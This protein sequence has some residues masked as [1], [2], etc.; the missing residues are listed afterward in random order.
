[1]N[2][3]KFN[4][5]Q[6]G[7]HLM[8]AASGANATVAC[9][10]C[11]QAIIV[12][13]PAPAMV[14]PERTMPGAKAGDGPAPTVRNQRAVAAK[15]KSPVA[16]VAALALGVCLVG[17]VLFAFRENIF[18]STP[19]PRHVVRAPKPAAQLCG[20]AQAAVVQCIAKSAPAP[21]AILSA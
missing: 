4:C 5:P 15:K 21:I 8:V 7:Q 2:D 20:L 19:A 12:P 14:I 17:A 9:P 16:M 3:I 10:Q 1:M 18:N 11:G 6:C 13:S